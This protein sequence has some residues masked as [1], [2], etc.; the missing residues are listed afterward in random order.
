MKKI[1]EENYGA[2]S[3]MVMEAP[4][5]WAFSEGSGSRAVHWDPKIPARTSFQ[6]FNRE[7]VLVTFS[8]SPSRCPMAL[9]L[10]TFP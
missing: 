4:E 10:A 3:V 6:V 8:Q 7:K 5:P 2:K 1:A 9:M